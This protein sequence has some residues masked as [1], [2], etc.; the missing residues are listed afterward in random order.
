[1]G[2]SSR[3]L[4]DD[5]QTAGKEGGVRQVLPPGARLAHLETRLGRGRPAGGGWREESGQ[6]PGQ[7]SP[8]ED[9]GGEVHG[10]EGHLR[11]K[12]SGM[13]P[14]FLHSG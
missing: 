12:G 2:P 6:P 10:G 5:K 14:G 8:G 3:D 11:P 7:G 4:E 9:H 13:S 1:M